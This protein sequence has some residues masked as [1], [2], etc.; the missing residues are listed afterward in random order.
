MEGVGILAAGSRESILLSSGAGAEESRWRR[1]RFSGLIL[2]LFTFYLVSWAFGAS[3]LLWLCCCCCCESSSN[4]KRLLL[5]LSFINESR[6]IIHQNRG[7]SKSYSIAENNTLT[8]RIIPHR[9]PFIFLYDVL[10][11]ERRPSHNME[12]MYYHYCCF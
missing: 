4:N 2:L 10:Y 1:A 8:T 12:H 11:D 3:V 5:L 9:D 7:A 6:Q